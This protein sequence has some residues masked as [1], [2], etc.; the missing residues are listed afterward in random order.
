MIDKLWKLFKE[1]GDVRIFNLL[2]KVEGSKRNGKH[3]SR[4][5][6]TRGN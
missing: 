3:K 2:G 5:N 1:T 6:S 4:R